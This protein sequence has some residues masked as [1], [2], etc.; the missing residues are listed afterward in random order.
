MEEQNTSSLSVFVTGAT[1]GLGRAVMRRLVAAGHRVA[2]AANSLEEA[3]MI[4]ADGGLPVYNGLF[5]AGEIASTLKL[6]KADVLV[7]AAPQYINGLP[8]NNPDW[9]YYTR[10]L[11]E[12][13]A[14]CVE[15]AAQTGVKFIVHTSYAFLY[16][17]THGSA[18]DENASLEAGNSF[19]SAAASAEQ[20]VL[21]GETPGCVLRAGFTYGPESASIR[22]LQRALISG[23]NLHLA[24]HQA[25]WIHTDDLASAIVAAAEQQPAGEIFNIVD[26]APVSP[27]AFVDHFAAS[28]GLNPP[29]RASVPQPLKQYVIPDAVRALLAT[30]GVASNAKAKE[31]LGWSPAYAS[32]Q[33]GIE[34]TLLMWRAAEAG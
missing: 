18:V 3:N 21:N 8:L 13:T 29:G 24:D 1:E 31:K 27:G 16:G 6:V 14:A 9:A 25:S 23:G 19:F 4:R 12:S 17:D 32:Y 11:N 7:N 10:L 26:D 22:A 5:R 30:S 28:M 34:Q 15:A 33:N 2:G 20:M